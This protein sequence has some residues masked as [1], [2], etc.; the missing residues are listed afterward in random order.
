MKIGDTV[1]VKPAFFGY[2]SFSYMP[3][4]AKYYRQSHKI[5]G[6]RERT[7]RSGTFV[8]KIALPKRFHTLFGNPFWE[9]DANRLDLVKSCKPQKCKWGNCGKIHDEDIP[10]TTVNSNA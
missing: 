8:A 9:L 1:K 3:T 5:A 4:V 6:F 7:S 10:V 2:L